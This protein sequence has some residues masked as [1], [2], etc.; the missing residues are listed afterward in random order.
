[1]ACCARQ[2]HLFPSNADL[3]SVTV[4]WF[5]SEPV[6]PSVRS[7]SFRVPSISFPLGTF[8][9][10]TL[11]YPGFRSSSRYD[12]AASTGRGGFQVSAT[13]RPQVF[14]TSRRFTPHPG[15]RACFIPQPRQGFLTVQG[16][17]PSPGRTLFRKPVAPLPLLL[18]PLSVRRRTPRI[19]PLDFEALLRAKM[20][21]DDSLF[22]L[23]AGRSPHR[24][25]PLAGP[26]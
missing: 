21:S 25:R 13:F 1:L 8:P 22:R 3:F 12:Q 11:T 10:R 20:R 2:N 26:N 4:P 24:V 15:S 5:V 6:H 9:C 19:R 16:L 17:L 18:D 23:T 14:A 7:C